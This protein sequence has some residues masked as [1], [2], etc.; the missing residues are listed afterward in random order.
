MTTEFWILRYLIVG[1]IRNSEV[2]RIICVVG[3]IEN[4]VDILSISRFDLFV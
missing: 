4:I 3:F 2:R 1:F